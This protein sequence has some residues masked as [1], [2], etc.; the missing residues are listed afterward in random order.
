MGRLRT[1]TRGFRVSFG[2]FGAAVAALLV[3]SIGVL[4][5]DDPN[6]DVPD[7][8]GVGLATSTTNFGGAAPLGSPNTVRHWSGQTPNGADGVTYRYNIVGADPSTGGS[9]VVGVDIIPVDLTVNGMAFNGSGIAGGVL[10]SPLFTAGNYTSTM[11][12]STPTGG[13]GKTGGPLSAG[14]TGVQYVDAA[15]R[16][17]FDAVGTTYHLVLDP[18]VL[19][20]A[21]IDVSSD[22]GTTMTNPF[23]G[24]TFA[25][26]DQHWFSTRIQN[27]LGRRHLD[28]TRLALFVTYDVLLYDGTPAN[29]CSMGGHGAGNAASPTSNGSAHGNG[30]QQVQT[31]AWASWLSAG[32]LSSKTQWFEQDVYSI[33]HE[34]M[35]WANNPFADNTVQPWTSAAAPQYGCSNEFETAD[36]V[37]NLGFTLG[38]NTTWDQ[39]KF[40]ADHQFHLSEEALLPWFMRSAPATQASQSGGSRFTL[41]G[42]L[43][44]LA[45][46]H[47]PAPGC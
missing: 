35:E 34:L 10:A 29:C 25:Y 14:N 44:Q 7:N 21:V 5:D 12:V 13:R 9:A 6:A 36:P 41:M 27:Q 15:M 16:A 40:A 38:V 24:V 11:R 1:P 39:S 42:D 4:A 22:H 31:F 26:V 33:S 8:P 20:P 30:N 2:A 3:A 46:F 23:T 18:T 45:T 19:D 32:F 43:N 47:Q 37:V 28:P 17:Q